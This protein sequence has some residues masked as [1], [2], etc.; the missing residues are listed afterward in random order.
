[1]KNALE[2]KDVD[3]AA[4]QKEASRKAKE[5]KEKLKTVGKLE[6]EKKALEVTVQKSKEELVELKRSHAE[7]ETK[8]KH[9]AAKKAELEEYVEE[10]NGEAN[11]NLKG[12]LSK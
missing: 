10:F 9:I 1:M 11:E 4:A 6:E 8:L 7:W 5:A 2:K 3:L 12:N